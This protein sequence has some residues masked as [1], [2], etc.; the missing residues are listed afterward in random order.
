MFS[1]VA[2]ALPSVS[3][4]KGQPPPYRASHAGAGRVLFGG[5]DIGGGGDAAK[6]GERE[7]ERGITRVATLH[8]ASPPP[9]PS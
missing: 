2:D 5:G 9:A 3:P 4:R 8:L 6:R 1:A 7:G